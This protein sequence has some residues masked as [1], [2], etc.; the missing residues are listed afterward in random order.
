MPPAFRASL[1]SA[2]V[3]A[4]LTSDLTSMPFEMEEMVDDGWGIFLRFLEGRVVFAGKT[5]KSLLIY[6]YIYS[7]QLT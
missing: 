2:V 3:R 7:S 6:I 1:A 4:V 5:V